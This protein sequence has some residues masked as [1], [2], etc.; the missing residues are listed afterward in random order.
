MLTLVQ[1][2]AQMSSAHDK[3]KEDLNGTE[4]AGGARWLCVGV[5]VCV[6]VRVCVLTADEVAA[7]RN[8]LHPLQLR[9]DALERIDHLIERLAS[10]HSADPRYNPL[11]MLPALCC[12]SI[13]RR[14]FIVCL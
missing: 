1:L 12:C 11:H 7:E 13:E 9:A 3:G 6:C 8:S 14:A 10:Q 2:I 5:H 4:D